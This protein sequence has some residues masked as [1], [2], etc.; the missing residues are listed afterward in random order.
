MPEDKCHY[1]NAVK[2]LELEI[3]YADTAYESFKEG[4]QNDRE[5]AD[6]AQEKYDLACELRHAANILIESKPSGVL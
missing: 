2:I 3:K 5:L 6:K 4:C 1:P